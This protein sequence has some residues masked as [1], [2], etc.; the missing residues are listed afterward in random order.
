MKLG[1]VICKLRCDSQMD[2]LVHYHGKPS[3]VMGIQAPIWD[4]E[5]YMVLID[6]GMGHTL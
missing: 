6:I 4:F 5:V 2:I 3:I 1:C